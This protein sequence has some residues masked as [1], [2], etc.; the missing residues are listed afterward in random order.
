MV[1]LSS[2]QAS[3]TLE[4]YYRACLPAEIQMLKI[5]DWMFIGWSGEVF[6]EYALQVMSA[7]DNVFV[8]SMANGEM[9]GYIVTEEAALEGGYEASNALF[10]H[11]TGAI[12]VR[13]TV[14][15]CR[16]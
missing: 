1:T 9:Q 3:G 16:G 11:E 13:K 4:P 14:E 10:S 7:V 8:I 5:G 2:M 12:L 6:T 15:L